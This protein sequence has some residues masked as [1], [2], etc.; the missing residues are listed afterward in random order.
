MDYDAIVEE[1]V[2]ANRILAAQGVVDAFGHVSARHPQKPDRFLLARS[3][4]PELVEANDIMEFTLEGVAVDPRGRKGYLERYIH[5]GL[6]EA[7]PDVQSVVHNHSR[8]VIP[9]GLTGQKLQPV[10]HSSGTIGSEVPVWDAREVFGDTDLLV[11]NVAMGRDLAKAFG[12]GNCALMRGHGCTVAGKS[13]REA[14][15][16]AFYL[17]VN[18]GLQLEA[19]RMGKINF[20][21]PGEIEKVSA[22]LA[23]GKPGEGFDRFWEYWRRRAGLGSSNRS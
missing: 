11:S 2:A 9:F 1:L 12:G 15:Y 4:S 14:V 20:L 16:T 7:R 18:A 17:E 3:I 23:Q 19:S 8:G 13:I 10:V 5:G 22:R 6:Y 21:T